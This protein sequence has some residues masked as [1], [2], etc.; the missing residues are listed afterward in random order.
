MKKVPE[1][2]SIR[3]MQGKKWTDVEALWD[4]EIDMQEDPPKMYDHDVYKLKSKDMAYYGELP[5]TDA[6]R[7]VVCN[8][9]ER[10]VKPQG[11]QDHLTNK[12]PSMWHFTAMCIFA[13][14]FS[15]YS[16]R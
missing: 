2:I 13:R 14:N 5:K 8:I 4:D 15:I 12:H 1:V 10:V 16:C 3:S 6:F 7:L 9:C 11:L